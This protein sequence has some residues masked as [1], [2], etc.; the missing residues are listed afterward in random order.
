MGLVKWQR[1]GY[2]SSVC[3]IAVRVYSARRKDLFHKQFKKSLISFCNSLELVA[4]SDSS[5][6]AKDENLLLK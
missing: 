5:E 3:G 1:H 2:C 6:S 4:L